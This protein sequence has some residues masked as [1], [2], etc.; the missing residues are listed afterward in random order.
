MNMIS[1]MIRYGISKG[2]RYKANLY[3]WVIAD[4][5]LY[6][7]IFLM[8]MML[9]SKV[10]NLGGYGQ[11]EMLLYISTYFLINNMYAIFFSEATSEYAQSLIDGSYS[12]YQLAPISAMKTFIVSN[13]NF[14]ACI[15]SPILLA[16]NL[17]FLKQNH[18]LSV[19]LVQY[20][21][22][23]AVAV[24]I[25]LLLFASIYSLLFFKI[26]SSALGSVISQLLTIAEKPDSIFND[27]FRFFFT[28]CIPAFMI[29]AVP[30]KYVLG[31]ASIVDVSAMI[32]CPLVFLGIFKFMTFWGRSK[33]IPEEG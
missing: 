6:L 12:F 18:V 5:S 16:F 32:A 20:Y 23:M 2:M 28:Y 27:K 11:N 29:S 13:F 10:D 26:R 8:Y 7:S 30:T 19:R 15:S 22:L 3:S 4:I 24:F 31:K 21:C 14:P 9:F 1:N 25:M 33:Y 17:F